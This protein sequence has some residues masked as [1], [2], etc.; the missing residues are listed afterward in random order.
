MRLALVA[1]GS[2]LLLSVAA[3]SNPNGIVGTSATGGT[4]M[5]AASTAPRSAAQ[6]PQNPNSLPQGA[7]V[8]APVSTNIGRVGTTAY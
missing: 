4:A 3:C 5:G 1:S 6:M 7:A 8:S 2:L